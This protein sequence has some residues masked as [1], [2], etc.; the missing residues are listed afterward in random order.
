MPSQ[1][2]ASTF[3][4]FIQLESFSGF[5]SQ[6]HISFRT[7]L[8]SHYFLI[9]PFKAPTPQAQSALLVSVKRAPMYSKDLG[10]FADKSL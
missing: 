10:C 4:F 5:I 6:K 7:V 9:C 8:Q 1:I 3:S 2:F